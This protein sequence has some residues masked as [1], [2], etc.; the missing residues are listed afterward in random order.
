MSIWKTLKGE[1]PNKSKRVMVLTTNNRI[2]HSSYNPE[3]GKF[4]TRY[5]WVKKTLN[6]RRWCYEDDLA[7]KVL[8]EINS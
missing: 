1:I 5:G 6:C 8:D 7:K 4:Y 2:V 3:N